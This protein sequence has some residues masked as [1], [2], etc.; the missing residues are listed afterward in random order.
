MILTVELFFVNCRCK[1][2]LMNQPAKIKVTHKLDIIQFI[3]HKIKKH[4]IKRKRSP[5]S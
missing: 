5:F 1:V 2:E 4:K 3:M